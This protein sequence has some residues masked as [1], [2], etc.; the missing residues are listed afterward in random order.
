[1]PH[2]TAPGHTENTVRATLPRGRS[3]VETGAREA[4]QPPVRKEAGLHRARWPAG[5]G[6]SAPPAGNP[7]AGSAHSILVL[8]SVETGSLS[9]EHTTSSP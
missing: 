1:M 7:S 6:G 9:P 3:G 4:A 2:S 8:V 5:E